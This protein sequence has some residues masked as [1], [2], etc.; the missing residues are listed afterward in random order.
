MA[1][2]NIDSHLVV[3]DHAQPKDTVSSPEFQ[4]I[5]DW[6]KRVEDTISQWQGSRPGDIRSTAIIPGTLAR[7][8]R[9]LRPDVINLH[10]MGYG[11]MS[12]A[13]VAQLRTPLVW[14]L[15]DMWAFSGSRHFNHDAISSRAP[16]PG[17]E[18]SSWI[19]SHID[20]WTLRRKIRA[21]PTELTFI[22]PSQ[23]MANLARSS[24]FGRNREVHVVPNP[25]PVDRFTPEAPARSRQRWGL[26]PDRPVVG[27]IADGGG[28]N[29][30]K[31]RNVLIEAMQRVRLRFPD[32]HLLLA[33]ELD[34]DVSISHG[35]ASELGVIR[36]EEAIVDFYRA[37]DV[38]AVPSALDNAPQ[39][40]AEAHAC[41][42]AVIAFDVGGVSDLV[43]SEVTGILC[44]PGDVDAFA[45]AVIK[46]L[47]NDALRIQ[48]GSRARERAVTCWSPDLIAGQYRNIY[49]EVLSKAERLRS[50]NASTRRYEGTDESA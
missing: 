28:R 41:A 15:H 31:G 11:A 12:V 40:A 9:S 25:V 2:K 4:R 7:T 46:L 3:A 45:H 33:G 1:S 24:E 8:A 17:V 23:W 29:P 14:T 18:R 38:I 42:R 30:L 35:H 39:T 50:A 44:T 20:S 43:D 13:Q 21:W 32:A 26:D 34:G 19:A 27:F 10:W 37:C 16:L 6:R 49:E 48:M 47:G 5:R 36:A 22:A